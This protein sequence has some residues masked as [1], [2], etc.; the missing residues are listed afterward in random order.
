MKRRDKEEEEMDLWVRER[1][2]NECAWG[3]KEASIRGNPPSSLD[4]AVLRWQS[5]VLVILWRVMM[6]PNA[7]ETCAKHK[8]KQLVYGTTYELILN[9]Y[10]SYNQNRTENNCHL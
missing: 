4:V 1:G 9:S 7:R 3:A 6:A 2:N 5:S 10:Y 8:Y